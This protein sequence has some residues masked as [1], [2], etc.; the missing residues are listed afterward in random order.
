MNHEYKYPGEELALFEKAVNWKKYFSRFITPLLRGRVLE[1]GAGIGGTTAL[2]NNGSAEEW[3]LLEPDE[4]MQANLVK[5]VNDHSLPANCRVK[6]G[7][8]H[9]LSAADL[10]DCILYIDVLEHIE[11]DRAEMMEAANHL[12]T[13]GSL[14]VLSPAFP[15]LFSPF[16]HSIGHFR[17]YNRKMLSMLTVP[18]LKLRRSRYLDSAGFFASLANRLVLK[19]STPTRAQVQAWDK[20]MIPVSRI[21]DP[22]FFYSFG[23][24][25]L[26]TWEKQ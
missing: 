2:L 19:K 21:A 9:S 6:K 13:G 5:K 14:V 26:A 22:V 15:F 17:R 20:W 25:I 3:V 1:C 12:K 16:D 24:S 23:K 18:S 10:Y 4:Q 8:I 7:T 11:Q